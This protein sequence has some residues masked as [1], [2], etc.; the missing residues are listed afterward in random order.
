MKVIKK[1]LKTGIEAIFV[2]VKDSLTVTVLILVKTGSKYEDSKNNGISHFLEHMCFKGT[3]KR[4]SAISISTELD[5]IG[6]QY[7]AFT[8]QEFTGYYAKAHFKHLNTLL[9]VVS[10]MYLNPLFDEKE[11]EKEKGVIIEEINMYEDMPHRQVQDIFSTALYGNS[12]AGFTILGPKEN[13]H[14][15]KK[16]D[17]ENYVKKHYVGSATKVIISGNFET[18][19][20]NSKLEKIFAG[21]CKSKKHNKLKVVEKMDKPSILIKEKNTDQTHIVLGVRTFNSKDK[22]NYTLKVLESILGGGL[23]SRLFHKLRDQMG[24][25][26][27][28]RTNIEEF[29]DHGNFSVS[30][31]VDNKRVSEVLKAVVGEFKKM[32]D[33]LVSKEEL[34]KA[35]EYLIGNTF[36]SLE[37][38]DSIAEYF[39]MQSVLDEELET[40]EQF[41]KIIKSI[42]SEDVLKLAKEIFKTERLAIAIIGKDQNKKEI[43]EILKI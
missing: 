5:T 23:S 3:K 32:K 35:K 6:S 1:K 16:S 25:G 18:K 30:V 31:G 42:N 27:Y 40:P 41:A 33:L 38:S 22:R 19:N 7:N 10:D 39:G 14:K 17:F 43:S 21:I 20:L 24:V 12:P 34:Q 26:Y 2:P 8:S 36:L 37:S 29:S 13:I 15:M 11:I 28:I 9:D 4:P